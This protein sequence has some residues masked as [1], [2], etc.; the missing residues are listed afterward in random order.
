VTIENQSQLPDKKRL[1]PER[2]WI[3]EHSA[4]ADYDATLFVEKPSARGVEYVRADLLQ[5]PQVPDKRLAEITARLDTEWAKHSY[6]HEISEDVRYLLSLL[7]QPTTSE[8]CGEPWLCPSCGADEP[9]LKCWR[10]GTVSRP[11]AATG[12]REGDCD[13][14]ATS[15]MYPKGPRPPHIP[16]PAWEWYKPTGADYDKLPPAMKEHVDSGGL[17]IRKRS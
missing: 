6:A 16:P 13:G 10:C 12:A 8:R 3:L 7:Q 1:A 11:V 9:S 4:R 15:A 17:D 5:Q 14:W 2:I